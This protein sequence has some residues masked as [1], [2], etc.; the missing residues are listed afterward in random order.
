MPVMCWLW[1]EQRQS[2]QE[3]ALLTNTGVHVIMYYY[4]FASAIGRPPKWKKLV[5]LCQIIQFVFSF[6]MGLVYVCVRLKRQKACS[7]EFSLCVNVGINAIFLTL[8]LQ[9]YNKAS[10]YDRRPRP[11]KKSA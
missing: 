10:N 2:L 3:I 9:F 11:H 6:T 5:T 1:L 8:F 7:G 4:F